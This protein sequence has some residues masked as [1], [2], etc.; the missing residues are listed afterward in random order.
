MLNV[1]KKKF[2]IC[3]ISFTVHLSFSSELDDFEKILTENVYNFR[4]VVTLYPL[5]IKTLNDFDERQIST[6]MM[7]NRLD[8][9]LKFIKSNVIENNNI[10]FIQSVISNQY[11]YCDNDKSCDSEY[12]FTYRT[13]RKEGYDERSFLWEVEKIKI[14]NINTKSSLIIK[15][16]S[17]KF[18]KNLSILKNSRDTTSHLRLLPDEEAKSLSNNAVSGLEWRLDPF[19]PLAGYSN[20]HEIIVDFAKLLSKRHSTEIVGQIKTVAGSPHDVCGLSL[21][22]LQTSTPV[23]LSDTSHTRYEHEIFKT[24]D[25]LHAQPD[26]SQLSAFKVMR[27]IE[28]ETIIQTSIENSLK[29]SGKVSRSSESKSSQQLQQTDGC[30]RELMDQSSFNEKLSTQLNVS[31]SLSK[32][33]S[34][35]LSHSKSHLKKEASTLGSHLNTQVS[36]GMKVSAGVKAPFA[37]AGTETSVNASV[38]G[39]ISNTSQSESSETSADSTSERKSL[40][41]TNQ[42]SEQKAIERDLSQQNT[43]SKSHSRELMESNLQENAQQQSIEIERTLNLC[44]VESF[45]DKKSEKWFIER[46]IFQRPNTVLSVRFFEQGV[47]AQ[48]VSFRSCVRVSGYIGLKLD[49]FYEIKHH[50][51]NDHYDGE[52]WYLSPATII[53]YLPAPGYKANE[54][55]SVD[56]EIRGKLTLKHP[57]DIITVINEVDLS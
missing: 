14:K 12:N 16:K 15:I 39:G 22:C 19:Y 6:E 35:D 29:T 47:Q 50:P 4:H 51:H 17:F 30:A 31:L 23:V 37:H 24:K 33:A 40:A 42:L 57:L 9:G 53:D 10:F 3:C 52:Y 43:E 45:T 32:E 56:Y 13:H 46:Q 11:L 7:T 27:V 44:K 49:S 34:S 55:G 26:L 1:L 38:G 48:N 54:D 41:T 18:Q 20:F 36:A 25:F 28:T 5:R 8:N 2:F 21:Q